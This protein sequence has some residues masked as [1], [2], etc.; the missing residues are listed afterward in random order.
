MI[1]FGQIGEQFPVRRMEWI[2]A[3]ILMF[4]GIRLLD[5]AETFAQPAFRELAAIAS[6]GTWGNLLFYCGLFRLIVLYRNG[7]WK[8][9]PEIRGAFAIFGGLIFVALAYGIEVSGVASTGSITYAFL[10]MGEGSNIWTAAKD[11]RV[12]YSERIHGKHPS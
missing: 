3:G 6:E 11:A 1:I 4:L 8:P 9:S 2:S 10:A 7:A 5:P 12:P